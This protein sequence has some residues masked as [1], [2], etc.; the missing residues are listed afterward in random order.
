MSSIGAPLMPVH[1]DDFFEDAGLGDLTYGGR[2]INHVLL[3]SLRAGPVAGSSDVD[4][5]VALARLVHD[6]LL[7]YGTGGGE[8]LDD[9]SLREALLALGAICGRLGVPYKVP[10]RDFTDFRSFWLRQG[11]SGSWQACRDLLMATFGAMHEHLEL[12]E[13]DSLAATLARPISPRTQTGWPAVDH[14]VNEL[15]RQFLTAQTPQDYNAVGLVCV[16][17]TEAFERDRVRTG[18][19]PRGRRDRAT[20]Y[21]HEAATRSLR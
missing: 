17:V 5:G 18:S 10:F 3:R 6:E 1:A 21:Q 11:A 19:P 7:K 12:L 15:R 14:E 16:R 8:V 20:C 13:Q 2:V 4:A 9:G